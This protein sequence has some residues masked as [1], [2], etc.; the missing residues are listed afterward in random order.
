M[1]QLI[2]LILNGQC[3][4]V[5]P[6]YYSCNRCAHPIIR[7]A[8]GHELENASSDRAC[9]GIWRLLELGENEQLFTVLP[10]PACEI[11]V[12]IQDFLPFK[13]ALI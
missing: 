1:R 7:A 10:Y 9:S 11:C 8:K 2:C 6:Y 5:W 12:Y 3:Y 4:V 13:D